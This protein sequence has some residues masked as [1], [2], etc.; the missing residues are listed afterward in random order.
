M[1]FD[2]VVLALVVEVGV[3]T[4]V[5]AGAG[6]VGTGVGAGTVVVV[7]AF[8]FPFEGDAVV[9]LPRPNFS[10]LGIFRPIEESSARPNL[11]YYLALVPATPTF[12][13]G[14]A[15]HTLKRCTGLDEDVGYSRIQRG[16]FSLDSVRS[17]LSGATT[18][19]VTFY[20]GAV[21]A[22]EAGKP[23]VTYLE[24]TAFPE[25]A[26]EQLE[27]LRLEAIERF[28]L[29]DAIVIHRVGR[30]SAAEAVLLVALAGAHRA[31]TFDA[32]RYFM[33]RLKSIV[34]IWKQ[35]ATAAGVA[36]VL[37]ATPGRGT[38]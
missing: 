33:D 13:S 17:E 15:P 7:V 2:V 22:R 28:R 34:P 19:G 11:W 27:R 1:G 30:F 8:P 35:E 26:R 4:G 20:V 14:P 23:D 37:G 3:G 12:G 38:P 16:P 24:Y 9:F 31:E 21:R 32:V 25:M 6:V 29:T 5:G 10:Q 18:G 36:W